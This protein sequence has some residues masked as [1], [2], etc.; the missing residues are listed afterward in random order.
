VD[1]VATLVIRV[2]SE[3]VDGAKRA[4]NGLGY[5]AKEAETATGKLGNAWKTMA[6]LFSGLVGIG[7]VIGALTKLKD[8]AR[9]FESL[10]AQLKTAT[11][12]AENAAIAFQALTDFATQT[13]FDLKQ[14]VGAFI[15]LTNLGLTPS[16]RALRSYGDTASAMGIQ[17]ADMVYTVSRASAGEY[18]PLRKL[19]ITARQEADGLAFTFRGVTTVVKNSTKEIENYFIGLGEKNF[20]GAMTERMGTLEGKL[21]NLGDAWD[22]LFYR[23]AKSGGSDLMKTA[24]DQAISAL[25]ELTAMVASGQLAGYIDAFLNKFAGVWE[26]FKTLRDEWK[27]SAGDASTAVGWIVDKIA[28]IPESLTAASKLF[29]AGMGYLVEVAVAT[30]RGIYDGL[31]AYF[32]VFK[33][34][35]KTTVENAHLLLSPSTLATG[36]MNI[37]RDGSKNVT[38]FGEDVANVWSSYT[39]KI[40]SAG[41]A[42]GRYTDRTLLEY[43]LSK[44]STAEKMQAA[45]DLRAKWDAAEKA[46]RGSGGDRTAGFRTSGD[47]ATAEFRAMVLSLRT[48]EQV[49][50]DSF[51]KR[52]QLILDNTNNENGLQ[53]QLLAQLEDRYTEERKRMLDKSG[54]DLEV[55]ASVLEDQQ[56]MEMVM[57]NRGYDEQQKALERAKSAKL[58]TEDEYHRRSEQLEKRRLASSTQLANEQMATV[59]TKQ[60]QMYSDVLSIGATIADQMANLVKGNSDAA[61]AMFV[62]SK[63]IAIAQAIVNTELAATKALAEGGFIMGIPMSV[64][65]RALGYTSVGLMAATSIMEYGGK[66][67]HGG[68]IPAG[69]V[70]MT[71]EAGFELVRGPAVVTSARTTADILSGMNSGG[72]PVT[73]NVYNNT[74]AEVE[75]QERETDQG[76]ILEIIVKKAEQTMARNIRTGS[77]PLGPAIEGAYGLRRGAA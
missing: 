48:Q 44:K 20:A 6:G 26:A 43:D 30:G 52:R 3:D 62:V 56:A 23:I 11:G 66:F 19:G 31:T 70:G 35:L 77:S 14:T 10:E 32:E 57:L 39:N 2:K 51:A 49:L 69:K 46:R 63:A 42:L 61:K 24:I 8:T 37:Y 18:E 12:S 76:K 34:N 41:D 1:E 4:L 47:G 59:R 68:M 75:V 7:T 65:I 60:L 74:S 33:A 28:M 38:K 36:V 67:E 50:A 71:Q 55:K 15:Q 54:L 16:E 72:Q 45:D 27:S 29:G 53:D 58:I 9:D 64:A 21:S 17:I 22:Q 5:S 73:V 25:E 40:N 13:P